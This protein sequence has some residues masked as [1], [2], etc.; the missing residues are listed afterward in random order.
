LWDKRS[1]VNFAELSKVFSAIFCFEASRGKKQQFQVSAYGKLTRK[2]A[3][4]DRMH[5]RP[6]RRKK[7]E[8][9]FFIEA[10]QKLKFLNS[11][12]EQFY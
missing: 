12:F 4:P 10:V 8:K 1:I 6:A 7:M 3:G 2:H 5:G 11:S 9:H